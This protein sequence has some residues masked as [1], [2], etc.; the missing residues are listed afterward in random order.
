MPYELGERIT[1]QLIIFIQIVIATII[2]CKMRDIYSYI[3]Q[4]IASQAIQSLVIN[5]L[6]IIGTLQ[7]EL[8]HA[9]FAVIFGARLTK[10]QILPDKRQGTLGQVQY[11]TRGPRW[12]QNIQSTISQLGP[13]ILGQIVLTA[14]P[15]V[16]D[17]VVDKYSVSGFTGYAINLLFLYIMCCIVIHM[18]LQKQDIRVMFKGLIQTSIIFICFIFIINLKYELI[19]T[20]I[21]QIINAWTINILLLAVLFVFKSILGK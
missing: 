7:H 16:K 10:F 8:G 19:E 11:I 4:R 21:S 14:L 15:Y 20:L 2:L 1:R 9:I 13:I 3:L 6:T 17:W 12:L 18:Q 5:R